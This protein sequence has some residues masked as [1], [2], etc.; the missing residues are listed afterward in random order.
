[1]HAGGEDTVDS[2]ARDHGIED[3]PDA[4]VGG[5]DHFHMRSKVMCGA[6]LKDV[7]FG[8]VGTVQ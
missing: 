3:G 8:V 6:G 4:I 1:M 5:D 2:L 7:E